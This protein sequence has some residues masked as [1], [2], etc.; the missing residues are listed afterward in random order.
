[1]FTHTQPGRARRLW[2][3]AAWGLLMVSLGGPTQAHQRDFPITYD[4]LQPSR[5]EREIELHTTYAD[6]GRSFEHQLEF[7]YG[8]TDRFMVAPY[9]VYTHGSGEALHLAGFKLETRYQL[10]KFTPNKIVTG[11]YLEYEKPH[12][13]TSE[14]EGKIILSRYDTS[15]GNL[16]F[17]A[18][19]ER[20]NERGATTRTACT[21]GYAR[22]IGARG[23][24]GGLEALKDLDS[25]RVNGGPTL[26][27][28]P[29][30]SLW[31]TVGYGFT[32]NRRGDRSNQAN[33]L[34]E[35]EW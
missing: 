4:W 18:V 11:L 5:G 22:P 7:E 20:P 1:M 29:G 12:D 8:I 16:S 23:M 35:Y 30:K 2:W 13:E 34:A 26:A 24:R 28:S 19:V 10:G 31:M 3:E 27:F 14:L 9:L 33:L 21:L 6:A 17:N 32:L 15:G 25:G